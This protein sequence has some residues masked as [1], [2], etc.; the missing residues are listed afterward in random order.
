M[1]KGHCVMY[2]FN[3][4]CAKCISLCAKYISLCACNIWSCSE[5]VAICLGS[6]GEGGVCG[7]KICYFIGVVRDSLKFD[8]QHSQVLKKL[9]FNLLTPSPRVVAG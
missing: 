4:L 3:S 6:W 9:N 5:K 7:Q 1:Y 2:K 8:M